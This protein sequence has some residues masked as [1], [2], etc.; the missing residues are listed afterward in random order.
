MQCHHGPYK[1]PPSNTPFKHHPGAAGWCY[2][3]GVVLNRQIMAFVDTGPYLGVVNAS[4][5]EEKTV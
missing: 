2:S 1:H 3:I 5:D 4:G